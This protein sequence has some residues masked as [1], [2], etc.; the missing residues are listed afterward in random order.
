MVPIVN[1]KKLYKKHAVKKS[2][3]VGFSNGG[4]DKYE[5]V[6]Y[7]LVQIFKVHLVFLN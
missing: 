6:D 1:N 7:N 4:E 2:G 3:R 5:S